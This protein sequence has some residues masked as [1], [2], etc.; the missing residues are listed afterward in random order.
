ML[1]NLLHCT[2]NKFAEQIQEIQTM[3]TYLDPTWFKTVQR[4]TN[5]PLVQ[6]FMNE[7][8]RDY[9]NAVR[10]GIDVTPNFVRNF[11]RNK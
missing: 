2:I 10:N 11:I 8:S 5:H 1:T 3:P 9:R 7:Y 6:M 4:N